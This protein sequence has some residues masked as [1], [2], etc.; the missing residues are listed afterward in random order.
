MKS[1]FRGAG[2]GHNINLPKCDFGLNGM[3]GHLFGSRVFSGMSMNMSKDAG[4]KVPNTL[5]MGGMK[6]PRSGMLKGSR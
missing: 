1:A 5:R 2:R 4:P 3:R 6:T